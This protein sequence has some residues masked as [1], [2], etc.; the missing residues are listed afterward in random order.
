[1]RKKLSDECPDL[2]AEWSDKNLPLTPESVSA[3]SSKKVIWQGSCGHEWSATV[4]NRALL[5]SGCPYCSGNKI[6]QGF[7]DLKSQRHDLVKEWNY[8][9]NMEVKPEELGVKSSRKVWWL[10]DKGHEWQARI[11]DRT[12]GSGCP[13]CN[14]LR[15][16]ERKKKRLREREEIKV[17][18]A[19][20]KSARLSKRVIHRM[21]RAFPEKA[22]L[23]YAKKANLATLYKDDD[24]IGIPIQFYFPEISGAIELN[25]IK[26]NR[27]NG[28]VR[29]IC[30][31]RLCYKNGIALVRIIDEG[32]L[33]NTECKCIYREDDTLQS[34]EVALKEAFAYLNV[35][36]DIDCKRD[37]QIINNRDMLLF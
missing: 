22:V 12:N 6:L 7:N 31:N 28:T 35:K 8:A 3:G 30:E 23:Y 25:D 14:Q 37:F 13:V 2:I 18:K 9:R 24:K 21:K 4:K 17:R 15:I 27:E 19:R 36:A 20:T 26:S 34:F 5:G 10:C 29:E 16:E 1:M 11:S 32:C 33:V